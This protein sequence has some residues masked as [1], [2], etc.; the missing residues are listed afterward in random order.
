MGT[1]GRNSGNRICLTCYNYVCMYVIIYVSEVFVSVVTS[2]ED[3]RRSRHLSCSLTIWKKGKVD[4]YKN[5]F[6]GGPPEE[7]P[8][9]EE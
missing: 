8:V 7:D 3:P 1:V 4:M 5:S 9:S 2:V 6:H